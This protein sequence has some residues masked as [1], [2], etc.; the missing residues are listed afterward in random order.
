MPYLRKN[1]NKETWINQHDYRIFER[2]MES[3]HDKKQLDMVL[4]RAEC[5]GLSA[6]IIRAHIDPSY[7]IYR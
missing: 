2:I 5:N 1:S 7:G 4:V 6:D 3:R